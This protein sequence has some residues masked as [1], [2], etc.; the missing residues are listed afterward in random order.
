MTWITPQGWKGKAILNKTN[1]GEW[2]AMATQGQPASR[3][4]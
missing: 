4:E 2:M 3:P 1:E